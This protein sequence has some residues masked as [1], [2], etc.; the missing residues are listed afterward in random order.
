MTNTQQILFLA[1]INSIH[2]ERWVKSLLNRGFR[3]A[4]FSLSQKSTSWANGLENFEYRCYGISA[5]EIKSS[6]KFG[7]LSYFSAQKEAR[8]FA[9]SIEPDIVHAHYA[10]SYGTLARQ[11]GHPRTV[12]SLWGSDVYEFPKRSPIHRALF[13]KAVKFAKVVCSTSRDMAQEAKK[14]VDREMIITPFGVDMN[15][16][17]LAEVKTMMEMTTIGTVKSLEEIYGVD[18][19]VSLYAEYQSKVATPTR[20]YIYGDGSQKEALVAQA[21]SLGI[22]DHVTFHGRVEGDALVEAFQSLDVFVALSRRESFGVAALEAQA[23]GVPVLVSNVG[24]LPEV[25]SLETGIIVDEGAPELWSDSLI[26]AA[27]AS[28]DAKTGISTRQFVQDNFSHEVCVD[29]LIEVY[30]NV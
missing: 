19:L 30:R 13:K 6:R 21:K 5:D 14:Y 3:I 20:L 28:R 27:D 18:R 9:K 10:S 16:F 8:K 2:T 25:T 4:L 7:K 22:E 1:D 26:N 23:C 15:R 24:G 12:L 17:V 29:K 11:L